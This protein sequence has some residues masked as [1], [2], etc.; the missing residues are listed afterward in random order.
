MSIFNNI[1]PLVLN[2]KKNNMR[3]TE[4]IAI[5]SLVLKVKLVK[6]SK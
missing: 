4:I 3:N 6:S 2:I 5:E 1:W